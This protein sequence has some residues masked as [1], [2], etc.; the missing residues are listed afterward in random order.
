VARTADADVGPI[1]EK[2]R[3][4]LTLLCDTLIARSSIVA[5][6]ASD[7]GVDRELA[8][9]VD[10]Y[11]SPPQRAEFRR[12]LRTVMSRGSNLLL[13]GR[14]ERF[15]QLPPAG[16]ERYLRGWSESRLAVKRR[17]FHALKRI[18]LFLYYASADAA[19]SNPAWP[20][21]GYQPSAA[22]PATDVPTPTLP[23]P[24]APPPNQDLDADVAVVGSGAG[25]AVIAARLA[26][27]GYRVVILEEGPYLRGASFPRTEGEGFDRML[28]SHGLLTTR[29]LA[30][31]VLAGRAAGGST[32]V[33]WMTCLRPPPEVLA[34]WASDFGM[35]DVASA[36]F[37]EVFHRVEERLHVSTSES[38][39]N[40]A[41]GTLAMGCEKLGYALGRD[42]EVIA[43]NAVGC[44]SRCQPCFFGCPYDAK[45]SSLVTHLD[46]AR[47][48]GA[49]L[50]C[51][52]HADRVEMAGGRAVGVVATY[53]GPGGPYPVRV[54]ARATVVAGSAVE[55]PALLLRSGLRG[56]VGHGLHLHPTT[57][58][59]AEYDRP[60]RNWEGPMQ[61][62]AVRRFTGRDPARHGPWF[63]SAPAHPGLSAL[64][65]PWKGS[66][67]HRSI[68]RRLARAAATI[69]LVR[70]YGS[71]R[72][73]IDPGGRPIL[74]Y[75]LDRRD[76]ENLTFGLAEAARIHWAAG[77]RRIATLHTHPIEAG[78]GSAPVTSGEL[79]TL[80]EAIRREGIR[81]N[82]VALFSAHPTGSAHA[83]LDVATATAR[84]TGEVYGVEGLWIGD[85]SLLPTAPGVNPMIAIMALAERTAAHL[86]GNLAQRTAAAPSGPKR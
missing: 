21:I 73:S 10:E 3:A 25:G 44:R 24:V 42:Y 65:L 77:A 69:V 49:R 29:D 82:M 75:R 39:R 30:I 66:D 72:V 6:S 22:P 83:G 53:T 14:A 61:T 9:V 52:T 59:F 46:D 55:T 45:Q 23:V 13:S 47:R 71:G 63:E 43:R 70:D 26:E 1:T 57:A 60:I 62:I 41:N 40:A 86:L 84:P 2:E 80:Q 68:M 28:R 78:D 48:S 76:R 33:N 35:A 85:G 51:E 11:L 56:A 67:D 81:E 8:R 12:L 58:L 15:D 36:G 37:D 38:D 18:T 32:T 7:R 27:R 31:G 19:G 17:G 34:E 4:A 16:R 20:E 50:Y 5:F 74:D 79:E 64:A 54:R